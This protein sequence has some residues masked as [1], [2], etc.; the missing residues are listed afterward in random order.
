MKKKLNLDKLKIDSFVTDLKDGKSQ[1]VKG[2]G[3]FQSEW[4]CVEETFYCITDNCSEECPTRNLIL[5]YESHEC[6]TFLC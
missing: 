4:F 3:P 6:P 5:C 2:G 1:T